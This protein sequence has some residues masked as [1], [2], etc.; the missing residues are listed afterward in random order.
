VDVSVVIVNYNVKHF[1]EQVVLSVQKASKNLAVEILIVD[2]NSVDGSVEMMQAKFPDVNLIANKENVGFSKANNQA[3]RIAQGK[4]VLLLNPD[5][6]IEEDTLE[7]TFQFMEDRPDAGAC[8]VKM[9][10][11]AGNYH[12]E[13][14]RALPTPQVSFY[15]MTGLSKL[16]PKSSKFGKYY[17]THLDE[18]EINEIEVLAG[19]FMFM[20]KTAL[21]K[22]GL[23]DEDFFMYGEDIDLSYRIIKGGYK[24]YYYPETRI[25]HYKGESTKK[26]NFNYVKIFYSAM[27]IFFNKHFTSSKDRAFA[28][29][30]KFAIYGRASIA[31]ISTWVKALSQPLI[32][33]LLI[34]AGMFAITDYWEKNHRYIE[35]GTYP[36]EYLSIFVPIYILIWLLSMYFG[37]AYDK[38]LRLSKI[39]KSLIGGTIFISV[40]YGFLEESLRFS[41]ALIVLGAVWATFIVILNRILQNLI[42]HKSFG[43]LQNKAKRIIIVGSKAEV[44]RIRDLINKLGLSVNLV[45]YVS[46]E[47]WQEEGLLSLGKIRQLDECVQLYHLD[48]IIFCGKDLSAQDTI[49]WI[50]KLGPKIEYKI[51]PEDSWSIIGS[52]SSNRAGELYTIDIE[53]SINSP[54]NKRGKRIFD[55]FCSLILILLF[56]IFITIQKQP[57]TYLPNCFRVLF[58]IKTWIAYSKYENDKLPDLK[59]GILSPYKMDQNLVEDQKGRLDFLYAKDYNVWTDLELLIANIKYLGN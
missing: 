50:T 5:T 57:I 38:R 29:F 10:D 24:N 6:I 12:R 54:E 49:D 19:C 8:G 52:H 3:I 41:R 35:G 28:N 14:K 9:I 18:D 23:L 26:K 40:I 59:N 46:N 51:V 22:V 21:D 45:G 53:L 44:L 32:D 42:R 39:T 34:Y 25:I 43:F 33:G 48:E 17:M 13:S 2:N 36:T 31:V 11:G 1:L 15:K 4:Y 27:I 56:P 47:Y 58:G 7:K 30:I 16:F 20:R 55:L 37:G